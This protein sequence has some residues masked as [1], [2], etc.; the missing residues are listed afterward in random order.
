MTYELVVFDMDGTLTFDALDFDSLR[1]QLGLQARHP[2]LEW[3]ETLDPHHRR[4]AWDILHRHEAEASAKCRLRPGADALIDRLRRRGLKTA[5][6][7]RNSQ[8]S[9]E[10]V[11]R[12]YP[13]TFDAVASRDQ[14]PMKP[15]AESILRISRTLETSP[16]KTLMVG[17]YIFDLQVAQNAGIDSALL[18][19]SDSP[20][21]AFAPEA[22]YVIRQLEEI[23][24]LLK[25]PE[26]FLA[27]RVVTEGVV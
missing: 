17:D 16:K 15:A 13:L 4:E 12:R 25:T 26:R 27:S 10:T 18:V 7:S 22:T 14:L 20:I 6:L 8:D 1:L 23:E 3:I 24:L 5:L 11:L 21:P 2:V 9:V 19:D